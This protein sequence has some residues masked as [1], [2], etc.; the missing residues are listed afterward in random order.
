M[1]WRYTVLLHLLA[2]F[3]IVACSLPLL[4]RIVA[5]GLIAGSL[6][7]QTRRL[8][9]LGGFLCYA[10]ER[11]W[12][13]ERNGWPPEELEIRG[14]SVVTPWVVVVHARGESAEHA[15]V[16]V[17]DA[18]ECD[19]FRHLRVCLRVAGSSSSPSSG[20]QDAASPDTGGA[21]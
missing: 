19:S 15:W 11:G 8:T 20:Q 1:L 6:G 17:S 16:L 10:E 2:A 5:L 3:A 9:Q 18:A 14:S 12:W 13:L 7:Y 4:E 21:S